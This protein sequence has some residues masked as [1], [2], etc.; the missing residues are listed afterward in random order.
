MTLEMDL[1]QFERL[2]EK[3]QGVKEDVSA[4][5][6]ASALLS[7]ELNQ[8]K[9]QLEKINGRVGRTEE[10]IQGIEYTAIEAKGAWKAAV[11]AASLV[12]GAV[13]FLISKVWP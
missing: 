3:L 12:G 7:S 1:D 6:L 11:A 8:I 13:S 10:R 4:M 2:D 5:R 9:C